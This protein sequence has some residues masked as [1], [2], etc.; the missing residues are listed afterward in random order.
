MQKWGRITERPERAGVVWCGVVCGVM[1]VCV[2]WLY[3]QNLS[4][5]VK[6]LAGQDVDPLDG[7]SL[8]PLAAHPPHT[9]VTAS[10]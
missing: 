2:W 10:C 9:F 6:V 5:L 7:D 3:M 1:C 4:I 8:A